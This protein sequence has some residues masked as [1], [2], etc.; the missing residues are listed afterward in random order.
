VTRRRLTVLLT[1]VGL[2]LL[3]FLAYTLPRVMQQR[4]RTS[5]AETLRAEVDR[6]RRLVES[7]KNR[8]DVIRSNTRDTERFYREVVS[9]P[10]EAL[11]PTIEYVEKTAQE[12]GLT[13][14]S[15][16]YDQKELKDLPLVEF[17]IT[18]PLS[19]PYKQIVAFLDR[20]ER[21]PRFLIVDGV[22]L[23]GRS[24][25]GADLSFHLSAFFRAEAQESGGR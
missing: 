18:M 5:R 23:R 10:K 19:G 12:L 24:D 9:K 16:S 25:V 2:N 6:N 8:E 15:R 21:S 17:V 13:A 14:Q 1:L 11:L 4:S 22:Q 20:L 7:L 3:V